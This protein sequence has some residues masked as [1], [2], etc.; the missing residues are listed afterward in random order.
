MARSMQTEMGKGSNMDIDHAVLYVQWRD[1]A[2][3]E[4]HLE[5][6]LHDIPGVISLELIRPDDNTV[7]TRVRV[8]F[9]PR[10]TNPVVMEEVLARE[11][12][13]V[14]SAAERPSA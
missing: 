1:V 12:F 13:T 2:H 8:A 10:R 4:V 6:T 5:Q 14:L 7:E 9:D 3:H 11:G